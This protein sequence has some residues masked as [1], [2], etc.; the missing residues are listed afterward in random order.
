MSCLKGQTDELQAAGPLQAEK[1][2]H[3]TRLEQDQLVQVSP[4]VMTLQPRLHLSVSILLP[5]SSFILLATLA[6]HKPFVS[7]SRIHLIM[8]ALIRKFTIFFITQSTLFPRESQI[9]CLLESRKHQIMNRN[10][11]IW[12]H[13]LDSIDFFS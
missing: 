2:S 8:H 10:F 7:I 1:I 4:F 13:F 11:L 9:L 6:N 5:S 3:R 12:I